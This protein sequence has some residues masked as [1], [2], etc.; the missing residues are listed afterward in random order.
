MSWA[1]R[2]VMVSW[3]L[4]F[5]WAVAEAWMEYCSAIELGVSLDGAGVLPSVVAVRVDI[6]VGD[7]GGWDIEA[8]CVVSV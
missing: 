5:S 7:G 2:F 8:G 3:S 1:V 6:G 4:E